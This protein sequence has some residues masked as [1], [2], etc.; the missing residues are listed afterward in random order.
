LP[1][2]RGGAD[3][4]VLFIGDVV[5]SPGRRVLSGLLPDLL[6]EE[7]VDFC[8]VNGENAAGGFGLTRAI[9]EQLFELGADVVTGGNHLWDKRQSVEFIAHEP[10]ILRPANYPEGTPGAASAVAEARDGQR[11]GVLSL[12]G[13]LFM[14]AIDCPFRTADRQLEALRR[15]T[16]II[17]VDVHAEA[18]SENMALGWYLDG[19]ASAVVGT[20]T[21]VQTADEC[22]LP[23]GTAYLTD[24]GM[25]G[26]F[27]SVIGV[28]KETAIQRFLTQMPRRFA[29]ASDD[30]RL[31]GAL[32]EIDGAS[33]RATRIQRIQRRL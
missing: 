7:Q 4:N 23:G 3:V 2:Q 9:A 5:G 21:H 26:P 13:R 28:T 14:L 19:R 25:T 6:S 12:Q 24:A 32:I 33:G 18:T 11:V 29:V 31:S 10:R 30:A 17:I 20:H 27:D 22:V 8:V 15:V 16:P 1:P